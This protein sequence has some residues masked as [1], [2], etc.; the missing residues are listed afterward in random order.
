MG[1]EVEAA[2]TDDALLCSSQE[3]KEKE[4]RLLLLILLSLEDKERMELEAKEKKRKEVVRP[5][6][7]FPADRHWKVSSESWEE[8]EKRRKHGQLTC[9]YETWLAPRDCGRRKGGE[10]ACG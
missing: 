4:G 6:C 3:R 8:E 9:F 7:S 10:I 2:N 5:H 1:R